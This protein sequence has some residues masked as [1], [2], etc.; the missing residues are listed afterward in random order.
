MSRHRKLLAAI[1]LIPTVLALILVFLILRPVYEGTTTV[2]FPLKQASSF[3]RRSLSNLDIPVASMSGILESTPT[4]YNH[5]AIIESRTVALRVYNSLKQNKGIDLLDTYPDIAKGRELDTEELRLNAVAQRMQK[6]VHVKDADR[7]M[8]EIT[9]RHTDPEIAAATC[10]TYVTETVNFISDLNKSSQSDLRIFLEARQV[11]VE[12]NLI[13]AEAEI[14]RAK[15]ETG[16]LAVEEQAT[17][18]IKS[19]AGIESLVAQAQIDYQGSQT[20]AQNMAEAGM[21]MSDYYVWIAAGDAQGEE[22]PA[23]AIDSLADQTIGRLRSQLADLELTRQQTLLYATPENPEVI[24]LNRQIEAVRK[25][26]YREFADYYDAAVAGLIV[27]STAYRAQLDVAQGVLSQ[28]DQQLNK[29]P[30]D[31]RRLIELQRNRDVQESVYLVIAQELEQARIQ[32]MRQ[33]SPFSVLDPPLVPTRPVRPRKLMTT[34]SVFL[35][36]FW[37]GT[38]VVFRVESNA[39]RKV[40]RESGKGPSRSS[41]R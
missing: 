25:E 28:L 39:A 36:S 41:G 33:E 15:E 6:R 12:Q 34:V 22:P 10:S 31:E 5:I 27:E 19:Y 40:D 17:Q 8:A 2:I 18:L 24:S 38:F 21:D 20:K 4:I 30:P 37:V 16:I 32:E 7:G 3:M 11:E 29:F 26:L 14:E 35:L 1:T 9:F 23:P 13:Q